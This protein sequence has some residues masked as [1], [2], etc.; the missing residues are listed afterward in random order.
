MK[1]IIWASHINSK[2]HLKKYVGVTK[3]LDVAESME[4]Y[5]IYIIQ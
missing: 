4:I 2:E 5:I 3:N 1:R